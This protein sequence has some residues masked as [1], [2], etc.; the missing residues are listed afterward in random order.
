MGATATSSVRGNFCF[1]EMAKL[2]RTSDMRREADII[3]L[4]CMRL[5][6]AYIGRCDI[7]CR[8][9]KPTFENSIASANQC[10][11]PVVRVDGHHEP[12]KTMIATGLCVRFEEADSFRSAP[13]L[14][15]RTALVCCG[16]VSFR[17]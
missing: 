6:R 12:S 10:R 4:L 14:T 8:L 2:V 7:V 17:G 3:A 15:V 13:P 16:V 5:L 11:R 9:P 1:Q